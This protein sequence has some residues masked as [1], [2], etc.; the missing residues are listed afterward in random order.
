MWRPCR[1]IC[2]ASS[3]PNNL[4]AHGYRNHEKRSS[5]YHLDGASPGSRRPDSPLALFSELPTA[6]ARGT[7]AAF[8]ARAIAC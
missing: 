8:G 5:V 7:A 1:R 3:L 6:V 2:R 4:K